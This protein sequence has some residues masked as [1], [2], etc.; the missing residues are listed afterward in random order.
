MSVANGPVDSWPLLSL[1]ASSHVSVWP[2]LSFS[3]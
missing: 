2:Q 1:S 3:E